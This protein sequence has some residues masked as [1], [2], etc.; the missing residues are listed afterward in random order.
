MPVTQ[1]HSTLVSANAGELITTSTTTFYTVP[2]GKK[3]VPKCLHMF[4]THSSAIT[5]TLW[6]VPN[7]GSAAD[8]YKILEEA[9]PAGKPY[10]APIGALV[11]AAGDFIQATASTT[12]KV[13]LRISGFTIEPIS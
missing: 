8:R 12:N 1:E 10:V 6:V 5:V 13:G 3:F 9:I 11:M 7:G 2:T 4:N